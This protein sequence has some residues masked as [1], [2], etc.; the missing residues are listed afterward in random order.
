MV[1]L[2]L[3]IGNTWIKWGLFE[4]KVLKITG[5]LKRFNVPDLLD[6]V[7]QNQATHVIA[8]STRHLSK[9]MHGLFQEPPFHLLSERSNL[10]FRVNYLTPKT[11]GK[12]RIAVIAGA[13]ALF[14]DQACLVIDAG[15]CITYDILSS[16]NIYLG[17]NI[18]PGIHMR[19]EAMHHFT[20][21]LPQ[22]EPSGR[23]K[24]IGTDTKSALQVG[25]ETGALWEVEGF[26]RDYKKKFKSINI[27]LTGGDAHFFVNYLKTKIFVA[28]HLVLQG[29]NEILNYNVSL[30]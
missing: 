15:T 7:N 12:D 5:K 8:S 11:L 10:P 25:A 2:A 26:I 6:L 4:N 22:I 19:L 16:E 27:L 23:F 3:D 9:K 24:Q 17:G 21:Q 18:S 28:P 20:D 29:L 30:D 14:A 1:N 13:R